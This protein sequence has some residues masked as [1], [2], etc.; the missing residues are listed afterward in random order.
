[1]RLSFA[2]RQRVAKGE[3]DADRRVLQRLRQHL[4]R[5][6]QSP[7]DGRLGCRWRNW[8]RQV[9]ISEQT[10]YRWK[11]QYKGLETDQVHQFKQLGQLPLRP[12]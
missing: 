10:P 3:E 4:W 8:I 5:T 1:M 2:P 12:V 9:G 6:L 7:C 11:K